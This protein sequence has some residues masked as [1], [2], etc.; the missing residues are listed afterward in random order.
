M[1]NVAVIDSVHVAASD[2]QQTPDMH[3]PTRGDAHT[4]VA[5][6]ANLNVPHGD[7][8]VTSTR[9]TIQGKQYH[10]LTLLRAALLLQSVL[11]GLGPRCVGPASVLGTA[12]QLATVAL[13]TQSRLKCPTIILVSAI[14]IITLPMSGTSALTFG[15]FY[16]SGALQS[17]KVDSVRDIFAALLFILAQEESHVVTFGQLVLAPFARPQK[18]YTSEP[19]SAPQ[20]IVD[21]AYPVAVVSATAIDRI[22]T[23]SPFIT[24]HN[25][26]ATIGHASHASNSTS[27]SPR[28][29]A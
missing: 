11:V 9:L 7:S 2:C 23:S 6:K 10:P 4:S 14:P 17:T 29:E 13:D 12:S 1:P 22:S 25:A 15:R 5:H 27:A 21:E 20:L 26:K 18:I 28:V 16:D 19:M 8:Q 24:I 3:S